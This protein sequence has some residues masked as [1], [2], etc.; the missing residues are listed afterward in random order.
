MLPLG[1]DNLITID[2]ATR[3]K[4]FEMGQRG[5]GGVNSQTEGGPDGSGDKKKRV[6]GVGE[7]D[8]EALM[9]M[10]DNAVSTHIFWKSIDFCSINQ[11]SRF[12]PYFLSAVCV[13]FYFYCTPNSIFYG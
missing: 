4:V 7:M 10:L 11:F 6:W 8:F 1:L 13:L 9:R 5:G 12:F 2:D 3:Q